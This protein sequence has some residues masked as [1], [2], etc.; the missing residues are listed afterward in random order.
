MPRYELQEA[1][2]LDGRYFE[3]GTTIDYDGAPSRQMRPVE[4]VAR[5][6]KDRYDGER[7]HLRASR[8]LPSRIVH[9]PMARIPGTPRVA[10][11]PGQVP[12]PSADP[13]NPERTAA[14]LEARA[15]AVEADA[16]AREEASRPAPEPQA[17][18]ADRPAE[19]APKKPAPKK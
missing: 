5:E 17:K 1:H 14:I 10:G 7:P 19:S 16:R 6:R 2:Y 8:D 4:D 13:A 15:R 3:A 11:P 12:G 9:S 18:H